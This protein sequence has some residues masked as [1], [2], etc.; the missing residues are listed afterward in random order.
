MK[1]LYVGS[2]LSVW[3]SLWDFIELYKKK[4]PLAVSK[5]L[6][7]TNHEKRLV[8]QE[9]LKRGI[10]GLSPI[11]F[12]EIV[13]DRFF[14]NRLFKIEPPAFVDRSVLIDAIREG[15]SLGFDDFLEDESNLSLEELRKA[16]N[17]ICEY[18]PFGLDVDDKESPLI[19]LTLLWKSI[20]IQRSS[21][22]LPYSIKI[23]LGS[24][25]KKFKINNNYSLIACW[26][27]SNLNTSQE[28]LL[29][30]LK[31]KMNWYVPGPNPDLDSDSS[32]YIKRLN[33]YLGKN[34]VDLGASRTKVKTIK[35]GDLL[36]SFYKSRVDG[37]ENL[38]CPEL[39]LDDLTLMN[40][41][42][43]NV[44]SE[45]MLFERPLSSSPSGRVLSFYKARKDKDFISQNDFIFNLSS[46]K[47]FDKLNELYEFDFDLSKYSLVD[48]EKDLH[49]LK[50]AISSKMKPPKN[51]NVKKL[52][53]WINFCDKEIKN[54]LRKESLS[55][56]C[57]TK[58]KIFITKL[59]KESSFS[60]SDLVFEKDPDTYTRGSSKNITN[61]KNGVINPNPVAFI[62]LVDN[63][64]PG[65]LDLP[66]WQENKEN[67]NGLEAIGL[68]DVQMRIEE[69]S[70]RAWC[71]QNRGDSG[72]SIY[73]DNI[74]NRGERQFLS[75]LLDSRNI[76]ESAC[77]EVQD[78]FLPVNRLRF[79]NQVKLS[80]LESV[81]DFNDYE[82]W[83]VGKIDEK[84]SFNVSAF[85]KKKPPCLFAYY[86]SQSGIIRGR[87][88]IDPVYPGALNT[89]TFIHDC[90][91][92][93]G[94][95]FKIG[96]D[97]DALVS[98]VMSEVSLWHSFNEEV[99][100][101]GLF[102]KWKMFLVEEL[103][104]WEEADFETSKQEYSPSSKFFMSRIPI[105][106]E[107][108]EDL[109]DIEMRGRID[110]LENY[111]SESG[112]INTTIID[113]KTGKKKP[114]WTQAFFYP[115]FLERNWSCKDFIY[116]YLFE[117]VDKDCNWSQQKEW[118]RERISKEI[119]ENMRS[120]KKDWSQGNVV[121]CW[122]KGESPCNW[123][124][125]FGRGKFW[126]I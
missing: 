86:V 54:H 27:I 9:A 97:Y 112:K 2:P 104:R 30:P 19:A 110:R 88:K 103:G 99:V 95:K 94:E 78:S 81:G 71:L 70:W 35:C 45:D 42:L 41:L 34:V 11:S 120:W 93:L 12:N 58:S 124:K 5:I 24:D 125:E 66:D 29:R 1:S 118:M 72:C 96:E 109:K 25:E 15:K 55:K 6:T 17:R 39:I 10:S 122:A 90:L 111:V 13:E 37:Y 56:V 14:F 115:Y 89:G 62:G 105:V 108:Y 91:E 84:I 18:L 67:K 21:R 61:M 59:M 85:N 114:D 60:L 16:V 31:D 65:K 3:N 22:Y 38:S 32:R 126:R 57:D 52:K 100:K 73:W 116:R 74:D 8:N 75:S 83:R 44:D 121:P 51:I 69:E 63:R 4:N 82:D 48:F 28:E 40:S 36:N 76:K 123:C 23:N 87:N 7:P 106:N 92:N 20:W 101:K 47:V 80:F 53:K 119:L 98:N 107:V 49:R 117:E 102:E 50:K 26:G 113:Y 77:V 33:S 68:P 46:L 64:F 43:S 79:D